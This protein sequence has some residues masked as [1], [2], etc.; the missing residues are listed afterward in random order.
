MAGH[1]HDL[2]PARRRT[3]PWRGAVEA[4]HLLATG[5]GRVLVT[6]V[7]AI[8]A[9][10]AIGLVALWPYGWH[11]ARTTTPSPVVSAT[12]QRVEDFSCAG[13]GSNPCRRIIVSAEGRTATVVLGFASMAP[14]V[15]AGDSVRLT[16]N[17]AHAH[18]VPGPSEYDFRSVD[19][20][21]SLLWVGALVAV[22]AA[23]LLRWRGAFAVA[24]VA[25]SLAIVVWFL[26][27]AIL[28][29]RPALLVALVA[30]LAVMFVTLALTNGVG[31]QSL[32]AALG[33]S[34]TLGLT[35]LVAAVVVH[36]TAIDGRGDEALLG[37]AAQ[38]GGISLQGVTLAG[39]L[40]GA[41]GVLADT[42]VTQASAVM[43]LRRA[44][45]RLGVGGLY[46]SAFTIGRDHL[47]ATIHTL[48]LAYAGAALP[49][50]LLLRSSGIETVD[51]LSSQSIAGPIA[52]T[53]V[54]C[55]A[56]IAAVPLTTGLAAS[57][58]ARV[59]VEAVPEGHGHAH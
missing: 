10:T 49:L 12:V 38:R 39:M 8:A 47:S 27:P 53:C 37:L 36:F 23:A 40:I 45:P 44:D 50:M 43:A 16:R 15:H 41:L 24:G 59:P 48:V 11:P 14:T 32:A 1:V 21:G 31:A 33:I 2:P 58:V 22:M 9:L 17:F 25:L 3:W 29:G 4:R 54:G 7:A 52:A 30:A 6:T 57:L 19:H 51:T 46:R 35:C 42:A 34:A 18:A 20:R 5:A 28:A 55:I 26:I 13:T 56:L